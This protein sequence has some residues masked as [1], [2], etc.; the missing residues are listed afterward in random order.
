ML[1]AKIELKEDISE[2]CKVFGNGIRLFSVVRKLMNAL[3]QE[4][5]CVSRQTEQ[6][7]VVVWSIFLLVSV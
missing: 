6:V 4:K 5:L 3:T 1:E 2:K 7:S